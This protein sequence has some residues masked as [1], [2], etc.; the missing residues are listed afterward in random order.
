MMYGT[1]ITFMFALINGYPIR[2]DFSPIYV[3][4][5]LYLVFI[6]SVVAFGAYLTLIGRIGPGRA[7]YA[8]VSFPVVAIIVSVLFEGYELSLAA[9][10]AFCLVMLGKLASAHGATCSKSPLQSLK[11]MTILRVHRR[12]LRCSARYPGY[13]A[14]W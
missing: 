9:L 7:A 1:A 2:F 14:V 5:L 12:A 11:W 6:G 3:G 4:S 8:T 10:F 13:S